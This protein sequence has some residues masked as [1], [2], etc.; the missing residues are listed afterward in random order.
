MVRIF[1]E[2]DMSPANGVADL[3]LRFVRQMVDTPGAVRVTTVIQG[4]VTLYRVRVAD[5]E[6]AE[7]LGKDG[8]IAQSLQ[9][10]IA[11]IGT[12]QRRPLSLDIVTNAQTGL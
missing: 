8:K 4:G 11:A 6:V 3:I 12:K 1:G 5:A 7:L 10:I 9:T 2:Y